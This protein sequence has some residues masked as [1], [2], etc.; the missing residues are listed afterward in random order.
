MVLYYEKL[1]FEVFL[2]KKFAFILF[3]VMLI[4]FLFAS[5]VLAQQNEFIYYEDIILNLSSKSLSELESTDDPFPKGWAIFLNILPGFGLGSFIQGDKTS[6]TIQLS[7]SLISAT[8]GGILIHYGLNG[9]DGNDGSFLPGNGEIVLGAL[10]LSI[11]VGGSIIFGIFAAIFYK[12]KQ[13]NSET[14]NS[15]LLVITTEDGFII[16]YIIKF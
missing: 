3:L 6:A 9:G 2:V 5:D 8:I 7:V 15:P 16:R 1:F 11:G 13:E 12:D 14:T 4:S 10:I